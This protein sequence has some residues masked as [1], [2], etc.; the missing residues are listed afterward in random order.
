MCTH[1]RELKEIAP[2][3]NSLTSGFSFEKSEATDYAIV[4]YMEG[5]Y[6]WYVLPILS[7]ACT[8]AVIIGF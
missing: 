6:A 3:T 8:L 2:L 7:D 5:S 4:K 1:N